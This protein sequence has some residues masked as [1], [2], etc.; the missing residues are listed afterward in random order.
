MRFTENSS[1][2]KKTDKANYAEVKIAYNIKVKNIYNFLLL[3]IKINKI[4]INRR[5]IFL[6]ILAD[7]LQEN[8]KIP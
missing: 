3:L 2:S 6:K 8:L 4:F 1:N 7:L 5:N